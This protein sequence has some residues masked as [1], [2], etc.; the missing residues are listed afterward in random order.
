L[1]SSVR[2][3]PDWTDEKKK[4]F[5]FKKTE[6]PENYIN[7]QSANLNIRINQRGKALIFHQKLC[8][9]QVFFT[10]ITFVTQSSHLMTEQRS[11]H[12]HHT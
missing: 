4:I 3:V 8:C 7:I 11:C 10:F 5:T 6:L 9:R 12:K 2:V 1:P